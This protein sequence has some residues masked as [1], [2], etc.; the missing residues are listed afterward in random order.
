MRNTLIKLPENILNDFQVTKEKLFSMFKYLFI[1]AK[2]MDLALCIMS[3]DVLYMCN[4]LSKQ[5]VFKPN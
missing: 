4:I 5:I 3:Y 2:E 1:E